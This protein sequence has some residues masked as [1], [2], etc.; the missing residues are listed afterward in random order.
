MPQAKLEVFEKKSVELAALAKAIAHPARIDILRYLSDK[1]ER[2]CMDVVTSLPLSQPAC[3]R[4]INELA[5]AGLLKSR[6]RGNNVFFRVD[7]SAL[8]KFRKAMTHALGTGS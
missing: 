2:P 5:K 4:H 3:S 6:V 8:S 7:H 1:G